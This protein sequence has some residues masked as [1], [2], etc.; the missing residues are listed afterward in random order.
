MEVAEGVDE[1]SGHDVVEAFALFG[2]EAGVM[3]IVVRASEVDG[4]MGDVEIAA[5]NDG[6]LLF[7]V[8]CV[9]EECWVPEFF[10]ECETGKLMLGIRDVDGDE[11]KIWELGGEYP[12]LAGGVAVGVFVPEVAG[13]DVVGEATGDGDGLNFG[14]DGRARVAGAVGGVP[15]FLV[16]G[17]VDFGLT[18]F[19]FGF[20]EADDVGV[21]V[22]DEALE[23]AFFED[24]TEAVYVPGEDV[25][26]VY[27]SRYMCSV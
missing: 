6:F 12:A 4:L 17:E 14:E 2:G 8:F 13:V 18:F 21:V 23:F 16:V 26:S 9:L 3:N 25:H 24:G 7:E 5:D 15:D 19:G 11:E 20:L 10:T 27:C 22:G 1:A